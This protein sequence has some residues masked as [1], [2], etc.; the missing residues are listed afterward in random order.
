MDE[1]MRPNDEPRAARDL[2]EDLEPTDETAAEITGGD[3]PP[4]VVTKTTD[5]ASPNLFSGVIAS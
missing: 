1:Q 2:S 3:H 4:I 5:I